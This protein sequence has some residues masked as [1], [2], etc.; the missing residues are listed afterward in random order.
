MNVCV[1]FFFYF[2]YEKGIINSGNGILFSIC[3]GVSC[4]SGL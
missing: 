3:R 2:V 1:F 4:S